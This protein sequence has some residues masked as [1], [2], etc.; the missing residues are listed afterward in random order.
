[1]NRTTLCDYS[2]MVIISIVINLVGFSCTHEYKNE[3]IVHS[4]F[5]SSQKSFL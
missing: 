2:H 4:S 3:K 5:Y 1:M